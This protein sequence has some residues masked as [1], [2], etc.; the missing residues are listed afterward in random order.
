MEC[1]HD[2]LSAAIGAAA[3]ANLGRPCLGHLVA[4]PNEN[5]PSQH[6]IGTDDSA[7]ALLRARK[8]ESFITSLSHVTSRP[9]TRSENFSSTSERRSRI[10]ATIESLRHAL[11]REKTGRGATDWV[12]SSLLSATSLSW[13]S[14]HRLALP[15]SP[16]TTSMAI[17]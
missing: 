16:I 6:D 7:S 10:V 15:D 2:S 8:V 3:S 12:A 17:H 14:E 11:P 5:A 4:S 13:R 9:T 1:R